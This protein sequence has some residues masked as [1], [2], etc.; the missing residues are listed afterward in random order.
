MGASKKHQYSRKQLHYAQIAKAVGHPAR[1]AILQHLAQYG[2]TNNRFLCNVTSL[3]VATISQH[4]EELITAG[5]IKEEYIGN[6]H[7]LL[8]NKQAED[9][10]HSLNFILQ[11]HVQTK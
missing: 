4:T 2:F 11:P 7:I 8:L 10:L 3:S 1:V 6:Q 5:L 9:N